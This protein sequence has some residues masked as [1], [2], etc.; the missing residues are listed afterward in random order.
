[1]TWFVNRR[2]FILLCVFKCATDTIKVLS[3]QNSQILHILGAENNVNTKSL[4]VQR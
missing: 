2:L 4:I 1:V 3:L